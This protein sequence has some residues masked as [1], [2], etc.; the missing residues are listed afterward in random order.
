MVWGLLADE[1]A[2]SPSAASIV[3]AFDAAG[4]QIL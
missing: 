4:R 1:Y 3:E 2:E